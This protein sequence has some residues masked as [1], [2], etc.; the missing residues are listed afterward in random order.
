MTEKSQHENSLAHSHF[1]HL[2][3]TL[4]LTEQGITGLAQDQASQH[5]STEQGATMGYGLLLRGRQ[6]QFHLEVWHLVG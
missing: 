6:N 2:L 5:P 4:T 3:L 1:L